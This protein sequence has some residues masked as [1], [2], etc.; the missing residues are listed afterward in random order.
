M[1]LYHPSLYN[2]TICLLFLFICSDQLICT[3][4]AIGLYHVSKKVVMTLYNLIN[5][6]TGRTTPN[7]MPAA[8]TDKELADKFAE[9]FLAKI[10]KIRED[11]ADWPAYSPE[12]IHTTIL[13][14][15]RPMTV[16]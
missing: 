9:L 11:L 5:G 7:P 6:I 2:N 8:R 1:I 16:D 13:G 12:P 3:M 14:A 10:R 4:R 15:F